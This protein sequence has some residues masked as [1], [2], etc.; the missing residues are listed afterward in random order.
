MFL[1]TQHTHAYIY[2]CFFSWIPLAII[3]QHLHIRNQT[4]GQKK[5]NR[6]EKENMC[7]CLY[8][9]PKKE[10]LTLII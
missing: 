9:P 7:V 5:L 3:H 4:K 1:T 10:M 6:M 8:L 2:I